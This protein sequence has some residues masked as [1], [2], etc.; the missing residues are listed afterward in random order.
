MC[1]DFPGFQDKNGRNCNETMKSG[2]CKDG[3]PLKSPFGKP[4]YYHDLHDDAN[5]EGFS[6]L[7]AC[8]GCGGGIQKSE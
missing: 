5:S 1:T 7:D 2:K 6:T 4:G 3:K 8:C